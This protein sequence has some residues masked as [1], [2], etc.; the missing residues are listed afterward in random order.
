MS[1]QYICK[2]SKCGKR[3]K[4]P[5]DNPIYVVALDKYFCNDKCWNSWRLKSK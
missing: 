2:C 3:I 1:N 5:K 4:D